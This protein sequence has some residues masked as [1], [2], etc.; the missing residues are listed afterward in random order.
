MGEQTMEKPRTQFTL[1]VMICLFG[2]LAGC[3]STG[4]GSRQVWK[5]PQCQSCELPDKFAACKATTKKT[6]INCY[7]VEYE[8][9]CALPPSGD[10]CIAAHIKCSHPAV[11]CWWSDFT[12][13]MV[14]QKRTLQRTSNSVESSS[15]TCTV[16]YRCECCGEIFEPKKAEAQK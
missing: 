4:I 5:C 3:K 8:D 15:A 2:V 6:S 7:S 14:R 12:G 13:G 1:A 10:N 11:W 16:H 9:V